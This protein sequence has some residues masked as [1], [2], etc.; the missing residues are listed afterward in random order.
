MIGYDA[1]RLLFVTTASI[2]TG[3]W[4]W[5]LGSEGRLNP[6]VG[7]CEEAKN[8]SI[9]SQLPNLLSSSCVWHSGPGEH[10]EN[11]FLANALHPINEWH[12]C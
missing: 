9:C 8:A 7:F 3:V 12:L 1:S 2:A 10:F 6:E 4:I 5:G 11:D